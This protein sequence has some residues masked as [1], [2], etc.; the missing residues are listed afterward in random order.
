MDRTLTQDPL[1]FEVTFGGASLADTE[2]DSSA[3]TIEADAPYVDVQ[4]AVVFGIGSWVG[5]FSQGASGATVSFGPLVAGG[6]QT[7]RL[8]LAEITDIFKASWSESGGGSDAFDI[9]FA[10]TPA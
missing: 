4:M 6:A 8:F 7:E 1:D 5:Q 3:L 9:H 2:V 10:L